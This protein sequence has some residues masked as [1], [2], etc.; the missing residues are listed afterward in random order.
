MFL[1][2]FV[3]FVLALLSNSVELI[4]LFYK[5]KKRT[6]TSS[7]ADNVLSSLCFADW[8]LGLYGTIVYSLK[9]L[10]IAHRH[11]IASCFGFYFSISTSILNMVA[12]AVDRLI[13]VFAP[14]KYRTWNGR[15]QIT[16]ML[17]VVWIGSLVLAC[18]PWTVELATQTFSFRFV[19][20]AEAIPTAFFLLIAY[21]CVFIRLRR[22]S[23]TLNQDKR[24]KSCNSTQKDGF[25]KDRNENF[26]SQTQVTRDPTEQGKNKKGCPTT[27]PAEKSYFVTKQERRQLVKDMQVLLIGLAIVFF[28]SMC[29][30][31]GTII[32]LIFKDPSNPA[33]KIY[34]EVCLFLF[35]LNSLLNSGIYFSFYHWKKLKRHLKRHLKNAVGSVITESKTGPDELNS[36]AK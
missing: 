1:A 8:L 31:P 25:V 13:A 33:G 6:V 16:F 14:L 15:R 5:R 30:L 24:P 28:F 12:L 36:G 19:L 22:N 35:P 10:D 7:V 20:A 32:F 34:F 17:T 2:E 11:Y 26:L 9:A 4:F 3:C 21:I 23:N 18:F 29:L 27:K